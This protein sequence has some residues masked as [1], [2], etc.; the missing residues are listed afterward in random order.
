[1]RNSDRGSCR[2]RM[3]VRPLARCILP[4]VRIRC[5]AVVSGRNRCRCPMVRSGVRDTVEA[6]RLGDHFE[7]RS[8]RSEQSRTWRNRSMMS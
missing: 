6:K 8:D 5:L 3:V 4:K 7:C 1:M 2:V